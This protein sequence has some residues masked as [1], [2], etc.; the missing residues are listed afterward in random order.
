M[1]LQ[2]DMSNTLPLLCLHLSGRQ[3]VCLVSGKINTSVVV[4]VIDLS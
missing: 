2:M 1:R 3:V 4:F